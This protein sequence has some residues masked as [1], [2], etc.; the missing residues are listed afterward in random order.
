MGAD[1]LKLGDHNAYC[2]MC[3]A[4]FK[5][6]ELLKHWQGQYR[7]TRCWEPRHPQDYARG[8]PD[9]P[10]VP[11]S[12]PPLEIDVVGC[13]YPGKTCYASM[14]LADCATCDFVLPNAQEAMPGFIV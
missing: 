12:Q 11:W 9:N 14:A 13:D 7:C 6:S 3:G 8:V 1:Y 2:S 10:S 5:A 4:K